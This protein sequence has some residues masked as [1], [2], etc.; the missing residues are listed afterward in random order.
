[1]LHKQGRTH[2]D[3]TSPRDL[4]RGDARRRRTARSRAARLVFYVARR[5]ITKKYYTTLKSLLKYLSGD[6]RATS[7]DEVEIKRSRI[8]RVVYYNII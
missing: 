2:D 8:V 1:M 7:I 6:F 4:R 5:K 3:D